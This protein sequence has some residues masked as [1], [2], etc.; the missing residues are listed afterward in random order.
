M[1]ITTTSLIQFS[2]ANA[3]PLV[4]LQASFELC[5]K[6]C[7]LKNLASY[8][9]HE[10][11]VRRRLRATRAD[12][13]RLN[14]QVILKGQFRHEK[15]EREVRA[16]AKHLSNLRRKLESSCRSLARLLDLLRGR[17][18]RFVSGVQSELTRDLLKDMLMLIQEPAESWQ[19]Q[20]AIKKRKGKKS[21]VKGK[22]QD[23]DEL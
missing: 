11:K 19:A 17:I 20:K 7:L 13:H 1:P 14:S 21:G 12:L 6:S 8:T 4:R 2:I 3:A 15:H 18:R 9:S 23:R 22:K 5:G 10:R 16:Y